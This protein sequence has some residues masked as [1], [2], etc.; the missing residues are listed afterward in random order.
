MNTP[1]VLHKRVVFYQVVFLL[2]QLLHSITNSLYASTKT[3][4]IESQR[5]P[6]YFSYSGLQIGPFP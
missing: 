4:L 6:N 3:P 5:E 1:N 2:L